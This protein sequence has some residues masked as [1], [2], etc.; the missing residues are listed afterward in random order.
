VQQRAG[1][2]VG[3]DK[4]RSFGVPAIG[5][6]GRDP[7][8][9]RAPGAENASQESA[10]FFPLTRSSIRCTPGTGTQTTKLPPVSGAVHACE[11]CGVFSAVII[12]RG[13]TSRKRHYWSFTLPAPPPGRSRAWQCSPSPGSVSAFQPFACGEIA[14]L[15]HV[16]S[17]AASRRPDKYRSR[18]AGSRKGSG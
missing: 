4:G 2:G 8:T 14:D 1:R 10:S 12:M 17:P 15:A 18:C 11:L 5:F 6:S 13:K 16:S 9:A 7:R 3:P